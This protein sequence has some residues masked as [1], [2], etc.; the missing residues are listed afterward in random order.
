M[1]SRRWLCIGLL[2][3]AACRDA[4]QPAAYVAPQGADSTPGGKAALS[5]T[6]L[7]TTDG[8][9]AMDNL[10][11][12]VETLERVLAEGRLDA[13]RMPGSDTDRGSRGSAPSRACACRS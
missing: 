5:Q 6:E 11:G 13:L 12:E 7:P 1:R 3:L 10:S 8:S 9:I 2:A 4:S